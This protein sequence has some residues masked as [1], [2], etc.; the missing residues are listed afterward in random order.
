MWLTAA[1]NVVQPGLGIVKRL[2]L[3]VTQY[4]NSLWHLNDLVWTGEK[5]RA[6]AVECI[7]ND[8]LQ[9]FC[10]SST[11]ATITSQFRLCALM[12]HMAGFI[13]PFNSLH[14]DEVIFLGKMTSSLTWVG[15]HRL[16]LAL[17]HEGLHTRIQPS[18][19]VTTLPL[20]GHIHYSGIAI[21]FPLHTC[22]YPIVTYTYPQLCTAQCQPSLGY[23]GVVWYG[24]RLKPLRHSMQLVVCYW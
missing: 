22:T 14:F 21:T 1:C 24:L 12:C 17:T 11:G 19:A 13:F 10:T 18:S 6:N 9:L 8:I 7:N 5:Y 16:C 15:N 23:F 2:I 3:V 20:V 4:Q